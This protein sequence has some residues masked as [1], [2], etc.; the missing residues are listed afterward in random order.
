[1][2]LPYDRSNSVTRGQISAEEERNIIDVLEEWIQ[3]TLCGIDEP[4]SH[5]FSSDLE[6]GETYAKSS[7]S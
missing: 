2:Q 5:R 7:G 1:M 6:P 3:S 4:V